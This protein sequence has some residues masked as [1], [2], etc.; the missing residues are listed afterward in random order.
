MFLCCLA[1]PNPPRHKWGKWG[2][3][4]GR[5]RLI[6]SRDLSSAVQE[7]LAIVTTVVSALA[8]AV[9][10]CPCT[11]SPYLWELACCTHLDWVEE[12]DFDLKATPERQSLPALHCPLTH[13]P[14]CPQ[15]HTALSTEHKLHCKRSTHCTVNC[16]HT[17]LSTVHTIHCSLSTQCT[18]H[19]PPNALSTVLCPYNTLSTDHTL[20]CPLSTVH[21]PTAAVV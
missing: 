1:L 17:A 7:N 21:C 3:A 18:V 8:M 16:H 11:L 6:Y 13:T 20:H 14:H 4:Q 9:T 15:T 10:R 19:C 2:A 5:N 12:T